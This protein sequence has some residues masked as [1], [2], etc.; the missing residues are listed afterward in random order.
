MYMKY[1]YIGLKTRKKEKKK[2]R[3]GVRNKRK[4]KEGRK[5]KEKLG[6]L[7]FHITEI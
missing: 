4:K 5:E 1:M 2:G 6:S 7:F 3:E